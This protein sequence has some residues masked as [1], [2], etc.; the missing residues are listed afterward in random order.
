MSFNLNGPEGFKGLD[1]FQGP[2]GFKGVVGYR[3]RE[4]DIDLTPEE[5]KLADEKFH[6]YEMERFAHF[7]KTFVDWAETDSYYKDQEI[8]RNKI[9]EKFKKEYPSVSKRDFSSKFASYKFDL[10]RKYYPE[11]NWGNLY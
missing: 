10:C 7:D 6:Q 1:G 5:N 9:L 8:R 3:I 11:L 4:I 2:K